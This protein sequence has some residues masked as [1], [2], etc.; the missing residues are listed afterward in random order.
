MTVKLII[1]RHGNTFEADETP[2]RVGKGTYMDITAAG[3]EQGKKLGAHLKANNMLPAVVYTS[4][5]KRT[6][7]TAEAALAEMGI[8]RP[9]HRTD[10]FDEIDYGADENQT[11][12]AVIERIGAVAYNSWE[13]DALMPKD[14]SPQPEVI[15]KH[16]QDFAKHCEKVHDNQVVLVVT[17]NGI[18]RFA[19]NIANNADDVVP[20][21]KKSKMSTGAY[22]VLEGDNGLWL[23]AEWNKKPS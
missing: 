21:K 20:D 23:I 22:S 6:I 10:L 13:F 7:Q 14:W 4:N 5:L 3:V 19:P 16:W 12:M 9:L 8:S 18:A 1:A 2:R 17:S 15:R 11:E